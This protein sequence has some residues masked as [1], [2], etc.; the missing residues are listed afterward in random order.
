VMY[1]RWQSSITQYS[2]IWLLSKY[3]GK[4][5][6]HP[7]SF[8]V[9]RNFTRIQICHNRFKGTMKYLIKG[10][11]NQS[12]K[13]NMSCKIKDMCIPNWSFMSIIMK[14]LF[15]NNTLGWLDFPKHYYHARSEHVVDKCILINLSNS[16]ISL[17][18]CQG[19]SFMRL[20]SRP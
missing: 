15:G 20:L 9:R 7:Y 19:S 11:I 6:K 3:E 13:R 8:L 14:F 4:K 10:V 5:F 1:R 2:Q 16:M 12:M 17:G 18:S